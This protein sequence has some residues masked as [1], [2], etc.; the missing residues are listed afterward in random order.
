MPFV[1]GWLRQT[2]VAALTKGKRGED[3]IPRLAHLA[4]LF[5]PDLGSIDDRIKPCHGEC[6]GEGG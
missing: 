1:G 5:A 2:Q 3:N 4:Q 6:I